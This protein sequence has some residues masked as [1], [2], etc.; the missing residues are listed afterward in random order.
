LEYSLNLSDYSSNGF[1]AQSRNDKQQATVKLGTRIGDDTKLT[2]L[3]NWFDQSAQDPGG[4]VR[5]GT[6]TQQPGAF[7]GGLFYDPTGATRGA[8]V[9]NTRVSRSNTQVG[10]NLETLLPTPVSAIIC[11][12][13]LPAMPPLGQSAAAPVVLVV[14]FTALMSA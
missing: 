3:I 11:S 12:I 10:F 4:L 6:G 14:R 2:T 5:T 1:R 8:I 7:A 9:G 13:S